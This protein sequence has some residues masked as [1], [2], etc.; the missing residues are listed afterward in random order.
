MEAFEIEE[1]NKNINTQYRS[2]LVNESK[3]KNHLDIENFEKLEFERIGLIIHEIKLKSRYLKLTRVTKKIQE[4]V[5]DK[6]EKMNSGT[7]IKPE[8]ENE[9]LSIIYEEKKKSLAQNK[10][11]REEAMLEKLRL[12]RKEL[13]KKKRDNSD[14][15]I[16]IQKL[17]ENVALKTQIMNL[18]KD[19]PFEDIHQKSTKV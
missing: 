16:K 8:V 19:E 14:F 10:L 6:T 4:I 13:E 11:K 12:I 17:E 7:L 18:D 9:K 1:L 2:K 3:T 5:T 15:N